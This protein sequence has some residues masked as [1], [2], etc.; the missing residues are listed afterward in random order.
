M[1][2][3]IKDSSVKRGRKKSFRV[4]FAPGTKTEEEQINNFVRAVESKGPGIDDFRK[5]IKSL[6]SK[7]T[8]SEK[9]HDLESEN[10]SNMIFHLRKTLD[11][12]LEKECSDSTGNIKIESERRSSN[13]S[14]DSA[15]AVV[16]RAVNIT[17]N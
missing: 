14:I 7:N 15:I 1:I 12:M 3:A 11:N 2:S 10:I 4:T 17:K 5:M 9:H 8:S 13:S 16:V 6:P